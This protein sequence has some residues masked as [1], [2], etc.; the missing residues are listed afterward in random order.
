M[1]GTD[2]H[3]GERVQVRPMVDLPV[4]LTSGAIGYRRLAFAWIGTW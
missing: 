1:G 4:Q 3:F 2:T